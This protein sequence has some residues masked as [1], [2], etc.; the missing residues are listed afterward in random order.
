LG[1]IVLLIV[2]VIIVAWARKGA[3]DEL[4][5]EVAR[6][7]ARLE[8][9]LRA[10]HARIAALETLLS[11]QRRPETTPLPTLEPTGSGDA[12]VSADGP[13][14]Q[15]PPLA[16][17]PSR[18]AST[19]VVAKSIE[20]PARRAPP[21][22]GPAAA[23]WSQPPAVPPA[24][25]PPPVRKRDEPSPVQV[26]MKRLREQLAGDEWEAVVG[27]SWLNKIGA[28]L[29]VTGIALFLGYSFARLGPAGRVALGFLLS[30]VLLV[31]GVVLERR[32]RYR[33][34]ARG[35]IGGGWAGVYYTTYAMHALE[36]ARL[37]DSPIVGSLAL[38]I[39]ASG[40]IA[41]G[42][43]YRSETLTGLTFVIGFFTLAISGESTF[44]L[45]A[46]VPLVLTLLVVAHRLRWDRM[47]VYGV[48][49]AYVTYVARLVVYP[50]AEVSAAGYLFGQATLSL[51][52]L[53]FE[54]FDL[55]AL[56]RRSSEVEFARAVFPLNA[57]GFFGVSLLQ[58]SPSAPFGLT[59]FFA[60]IGSAYVVSALLRAQLR[61]PSSF[62]AEEGPFDRAVLGGYE[63]SITIAAAA[64]AIAI[65]L[66]MSGLKIPLA[67]LIEGQGLFV[68]GF[69]LRERY[70]RALASTVLLAAPA[71]LVGRYVPTRGDEVL[72]G[73]SMRPWSPL[74]VLMAAALY[75]NRWFLRRT[76][77]FLA[78]PA[79]SFVASA[80]VVLVLGFET[81]ARYVG[82]AWLVFTLALF[83]LGVRRRARDFKLQAYAVGTLAI[84]ACLIVDVFDAFR[85]AAPIWP[86]LALAAVVS[87]GF[88]GRVL[89]LSDG[90]PIE[91][92]RRA[93]RY[94][95]SF[96][97]NVL[98]SALLWYVLPRE[99]VGPVWLALA[100]AL[101]EIGH[102]YRLEDFRYAAYLLTIVAL[103][104]LGLV[105]ALAL[106][107]AATEPW[108]G[109][110]AG[111]VVVYAGAARI[112]ALGETGLSSAEATRLPVIGSTAGTVLLASFAWYALP[113]PVVT[114]AW[115]LIGLALIEL[116]FALRAGRLRVQGHSL[117]ILALGRS[118][119]A[120]YTIF[121]ATAGVSHRLLTVVPL[122]ALCYYVWD[123]LRATAVEDEN[124]RVREAK[125]GR[126]YLYAAAVLAA[127]LLRFEL[128]RTPAVLGWAML[129]IGLLFCGIR[130]GNRDLRYQSY[131]LAVLTFA[132]AWATNFYVPESLA[133]GLD[134]LVTGT[135]VVAC[136]Y[137]SHLISP[138]SR[139]TPKLSPVPLFRWVQYFDV[140][141]RLAFSILGTV[142]LTILVFYE[143]SGAWLTVAWGLEGVALLIAGFALRERS[144]RLIGLLLLA[145]CILKL[146]IYDLR[147][148]T[149]L[150]RILS[151][152]VLGALLLG[153]SWTYTRFQEQ[154]RRY[155]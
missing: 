129:G 149:T 33:L 62:A 54:G 138:R 28:L 101:F 23:P 87:Y 48:V 136:F 55:V 140:H 100:L 19:T 59:A 65:F 85:V 143:V 113:A 6:L 105:N 18:P 118:F 9:E 75:G 53:F 127:V 22:S 26:W 150:Y 4:R 73:I 111:A 74:A 51:Y 21:P 88:V 107:T 72:Y 152:A 89:L 1:D 66:G 119:I 103:G 69:T 146:F 106:S 39:V 122:I 83:E 90:W 67:L 141:A 11:R 78:E 14:A 64:G 70:L 121:G 82:I 91:L 36:A 133:G 61:G 35:L 58:W 95:G 80:L 17:A 57:T 38:L 46:S 115:A 147:A 148:L 24:T 130:W 34:F 84:G 86:P 92:E 63:A 56:R 44:S 93:L 37:V 94:A 98:V 12:P 123:R 145:M 31:G 8:K 79:Y 2:V 47:L 81:P 52:W 40:M 76:G 108:W 102:R 43:K 104:A 134:R 128:G 120:N 16:S 124:A 135:I 99:Y 68:A 7:T 49:L 50:P 41:H 45:L 139:E 27:A 131:A 3:S 29:L 77:S 110:G 30:F 153:V 132:R 71:V 15:A 144:L 137:A 13:R 112:F 151:F 25:R 126:F 96:V 116:G 155:L 10:T 32:D 109:L 20:A 125:L 60:V 114:V 42:L 142:L 154:L 97:A 117:V 5:K